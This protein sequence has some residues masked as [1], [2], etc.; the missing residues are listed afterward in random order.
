MTDRLPG[1]LRSSVQAGP[2]CMMT[3]P[4]EVAQVLSDLARVNEEARA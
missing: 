3:P 2:D 1:S 4:G